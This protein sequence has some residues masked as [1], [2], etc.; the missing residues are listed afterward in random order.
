MVGALDHEDY[1]I[2]KHFDKVLLFMEAAVR[3]GGKILVHCNLGV[4]RS[5]AV[6]AAYLMTSQ[7]LTLL[8]TVALLKKKRQMVLS[9]KGFRRQIV[10]FARKRGCL[11]RVEQPL[12]AT[13]HPL[14]AFLD[15]PTS[16]ATPPTSSLSPSTSSD[17]RPS[18]TTVRFQLD[19]NNIINLST[20]SLPQQPQSHF[21]NLKQRIRSAVKPAETF[22]TFTQSL[23][24]KVNAARKSSKEMA[25]DERDVD[26]KTTDL[27]SSMKK[28]TTPVTLATIEELDQYEDGDEDTHAIKSIVKTSSAPDFNSKLNKF[29]TF[30]THA[31]L[32]STF[33][34]TPPSHDHSPFSPNHDFSEPFR[35][36]TLLSNPLAPSSPHTLPT[37]ADPPLLNDN[38][39]NFKTRRKVAGFFRLPSRLS[40]KR[41]SSF[42][43][44]LQ[45]S[46][47]TLSLADD[48][49]LEQSP[50]IST[51]RPLRIS[52]SKSELEE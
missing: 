33:S 5:G 40:S 25:R 6:A 36:N 9:N 22:K 38:S 17:K 12:K 51:M 28:L 4:N 16:N 31:L 48:L 23:V 34:H 3:G 42:L 10:A 35:R 52:V 45:A 18:P 32:T 1:D 13:D 46:A 26:K 24:K 21:E 7:N 47:S 30:T 15:P 43:P 27:V 11:D 14:S 8:A 49:S 44:S 2:S 39:Q 19:R 50:R 41:H 20:Q 29:E 37:S